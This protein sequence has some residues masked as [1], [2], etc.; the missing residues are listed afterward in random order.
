MESV[1]QSLFAKREK[2]ALAVFGCKAARN[3]Q[4]RLAY[5][6]TSPFLEPTRWISS[7]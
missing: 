1:S 4:L 6:T 5:L 7:H 3:I 2:P